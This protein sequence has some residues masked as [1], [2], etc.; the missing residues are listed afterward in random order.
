LGVMQKLKW[1]ESG[2]ANTGA[3]NIRRTGMVVYMTGYGSAGIA[4]QE[5]EPHVNG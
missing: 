1:A 2:A 5:K 3:K 4:T